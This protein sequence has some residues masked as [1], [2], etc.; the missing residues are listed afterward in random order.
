MG[1]ARL[2]SWL[3]RV[4]RRPH[5]EH[6]LVDELEFHLAARTEHWMGQGLSQDE[7]A[8]ARPPGVRRVDGY[9]EECRQA[10]GLRMIDELRADLAYG[11]RDA[12][13][14]RSRSSRSRS[15]PSRSAR[16][17]RSSAWS[18]RWCSGASGRRPDELRELAWIDRPTPPGDPLRRTSRPAR[19]WR[20][21]MTSFAYPVYAHLRDRSTVFASLF[22]LRAARSTRHRRAGAPGVGLC[23]VGQLLRGLGTTR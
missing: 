18:T 5:V 7:A 21:L 13:R 10:L 15:S 12:T 16:T 23:R 14:R 6:D 11:L 2:L 20:R 8:A 17:P 19:R 1:R 9:K 22:L 3:R 4:V